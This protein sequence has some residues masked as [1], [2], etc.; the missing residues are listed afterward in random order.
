MNSQD[1]DLDSILQ[2][3]YVNFQKNAAPLDPKNDNPLLNVQKVYD[4]SDV[5]FFSHKLVKE[6]FEDPTIRPF[7]GPSLQA[8]GSFSLDGIS[9]QVLEFLPNNFYPMIVV[10]EIP[11]EL[12]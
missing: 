6:L 2:S 12:E 3:T 10:S 11:K 1:L 9:E 4:T 5:R 7:G 8:M